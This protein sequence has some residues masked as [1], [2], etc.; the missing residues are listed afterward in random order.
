MARGHP[1][2]SSGERAAWEL[3]QNL[4]TGRSVDL[5]DCYC[6]LDGT[7]K[8]A[9]VQL[10]LDMAAGTTGLTELRYP[11]RL[12]DKPTGPAVLVGPSNLA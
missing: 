6:R 8:R 2:A 4:Q 3:L 9:V 7:G 12:W 5:A 11:Y 1:G 10:L